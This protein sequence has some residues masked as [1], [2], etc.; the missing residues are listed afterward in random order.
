MS[1]VPLSAA[2]EFWREQSHTMMTMPRRK[3]R[4]CM[5]RCCTTVDKNRNNLF[6]FTAIVSLGVAIASGVL[7]KHWQGKNT[8][9][10]VV[11]MA[12]AFFG[13]VGAI[14]CGPDFHAQRLLAP[15]FVLTAIAIILDGA[16]YPVVRCDGRAY[17]RYTPPHHAHGRPEAVDACFDGDPAIAALCFVELFALLLQICSFFALQKST[18]DFGGDEDSLASSFVELNHDTPGNPYGMYAEQGAAGYERLPAIASGTTPPP[19][20]FD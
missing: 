13:C 3:K 1:D 12:L 16:F 14:R 8:A 9:V 4:L 20:A 18:E 6:G 7:A 5:E 19:P 17:P 11:A 15:S 10:R 2:R